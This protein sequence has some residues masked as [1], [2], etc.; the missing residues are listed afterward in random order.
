MEMQR[1][2]V[3]PRVS[4]AKQSD[5]VSLSDQE[6][7]CVTYCAQQGYPVVAVIPEVY[8][9]YDSLDTRR[10]LQQARD[11]IQQG[12]AEVLVVWRFDRASRETTDTLILLREVSQAGGRLESAT[13][14]P[15]ENTPLGKMMAAARGFASE[16][17]RDAII[18]RTHG[19]LRTRAESG[20]ILV[21]PN[22]KY[23][24]RYTGEKKDTY[25]FDEEAA[26]SVERMFTLAHGGLSLHAITDRLNAE[27]VL[28]PTQLLLRRGQ[29][30]RRVARA[31]SRQMVYQVL[32]DP[33]YCGRHVAYRRKAV[34]SRV[35]DEAGRVV[36]RKVMKLRAVEDTRRIEQTIPAIVSE[37]VWEAVQRSLHDRSLRNGGPNREP[38]ATL[39]NRGFA[40]C[41][42]CGAR[43]ISAKHHSGYR[44]Y[45]CSHRRVV[46]DDPD[47]ICPG[48]SWAV[49]ASEVDDDTWRKVV[50]MGADLP[51]VE[52]MLD[53]RQQDAERVL[54]N[55]NR[56]QENILAEVRDCEQQQE[57]LVQRIAR[58]PDERVAALYRKELLKVQD[59]L[60]G[61]GV[62]AERTL[63]NQEQAAALMAAFE[64]AHRILHRQGLTVILSRE[65]KR[66]I[67]KALGVKVF[68]HATNSEYARTHDTRWE[69]T[70]QQVGSAVESIRERIMATALPTAICFTW[71]DW[72][73]SA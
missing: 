40:L 68:L 62:K 41:G 47:L 30:V 33:S 66:R 32:T 11:M 12:E 57:L 26:S 31:W 38:D 54:R 7:H 28:T 14:G 52:R 10:G 61:L 63:G 53:A 58:E 55:I 65:E 64:D 71:T 43:A 5:G 51:H 4:S 56:K 24:Y 23:G 50:E 73:R 49:R 37:E 13:E 70:L 19:A 9:G 22:A 15:I 42:H 1:A 17:E 39:L 60:D 46:V 21:G 18:A 67:L 6:R 8:S 3:Y 59:T 36:S 34:K 27:G 20:K 69:F 48:G 29:P 35:Q 72:L 16:T 2:I 45:Q 44:I 25:D